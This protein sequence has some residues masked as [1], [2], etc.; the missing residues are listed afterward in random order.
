MHPS[1]EEQTCRSNQ[2]SALIDQHMG[3]SGPS[4]V[5]IELS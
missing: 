5:L 1:K 4:L 3:N 2:G